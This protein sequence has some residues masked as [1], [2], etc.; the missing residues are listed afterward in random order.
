MIKI[1]NVRLSYPFIFQKGSYEGKENDKYTVSLVLDKS[2]PGHIEAKKIIDDRVNQLFRENKVSRSSF[3][4]DKFC[5]KESPEEFE[6]SWLIKCGNRKRIT[7]IDRDKTPLAE[8][9]NR[10]YAGCYANVVIEMYYYDK[11]Y[12]KFILSNIYGVQF[13]KDG[14]CLE[15]GTPVNAIDD[16]EDLDELI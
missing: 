8:E 9:D 6:N 16:F 5:I 14:E 11:Q 10:I 13:S 7:I 12:G 2:D 1:N 15:G 3:K 4:D